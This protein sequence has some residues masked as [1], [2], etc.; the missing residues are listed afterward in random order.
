MGI[1]IIEKMIQNNTKD[2][3]NEPEKHEKEQM[4]EKHEKPLRRESSIEKAAKAT[5]DSTLNDGQKH[6]FVQLLSRFLRY[7]PCFPVRKI[8]CTIVIFYSKILQQNCHALKNLIK[9]KT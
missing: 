9:S 4:G 7:Y 1:E 2:E 5:L 8:T 3:K 6:V